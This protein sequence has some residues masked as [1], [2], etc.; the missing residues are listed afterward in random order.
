MY[1]NSFFRTI[2]FMK[3]L[4]SKMS[5]KSSKYTINQDN[6][7]M[8]TEILEHAKENRVWGWG[9]ISIFPKQNALTTHSGASEGHSIKTP[10]PV[11]GEGDFYA[12][13]LSMAFNRSLSRLSSASRSGTL[14]ANSL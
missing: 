2:L 8:I 10:S 13:L 6:S 3:H 14:V 4:S 1:I 7:A 12:V 5:V 11:I 9:G